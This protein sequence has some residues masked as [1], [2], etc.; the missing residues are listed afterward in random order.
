[1]SA[2]VLFHREHYLHEIG[3]RDWTDRE[4]A[5]W[6]LALCLRRDGRSDAVLEADA[7]LPAPGDTRW[8]ATAK[9]LNVST[10]TPRTRMS[11]TLAL[12][13]AHSGELCWTPPRIA[14]A[15]RMLAVDVLGALQDV[16]A[17]LSGPCSEDFLAGVNDV[18]IAVNRRAREQRG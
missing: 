14:S 2:G 9:P 4:I 11:L 17:T 10:L 18:S 1:M 6:V 15:F 8:S 12:Y 3:P 16:A 13:F 5:R 7:L